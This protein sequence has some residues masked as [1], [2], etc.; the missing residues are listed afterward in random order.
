MTTRADYTRLKALLEEESSLTSINAL[1]EWDMQV[2]LPAK[3]GDSRSKQMEALAGVLHDK[4]TS[5]ELGALLEKM[6]NDKDAQSNDKHELDDWEQAVVREAQRDY[7]KHSS[8]PK[9]LAQR[10]AKLATEGYDI[11]VKAR[12]DNDFKAFAPVLTQWIDLRK[13]QCKYI[14][15]SKEVYDVCLDMHERGLSASRIDEIFEQV[16]KDLIPL[17]QKIKQKEGP[18][19]S[20]LEGKFDVKT[21]IE[22]N[23][24]L[25]KMLGFDMECG[26]LDASV[27][28]FTQEIHPTDVRMT[29]RFKDDDIMEGITGTIHETG[30]SLYEQGRNKEYANLPVSKALS[31]GIHESQSL[32]WERMVGLGLPFWK[33]FSPTVKNHFPQIPASTTPEQFFK[34]INQVKASLIRVEADE[35][36]YPLHIILRHEIESGLLKGTIKV[37]DLPAIWN[38][39]MEEYLGILPPN[40]SE[41]VLQDTHWACGLFGY[42][43]TYALGAIYASQ[44]YHQAIKEIPDLEESISKGNFANLK[45]WLNHKIH[46]KGSLIPS[47]D[48]LT[49]QVTGQPLNPKIF[50]GYLNDKYS[51]LYQLSPW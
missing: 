26:R 33:F 46:I 35:V 13:E 20:F 44:F 39:K 41:G 43:P 5:K 37:E 31:M 49:K 2:M 1:L 12:K 7:K 27:H 19:R 45:G 38:S 6:Q 48:L 21:Q 51:H 47:G 17:I 29:T 3:S 50:T 16:K 18:D 14:D 22:L 11:W 9:E 10:E 25:A 4:R 42:F 40:D 30:H 34:G 23:H 28:P 8:V 32:L 24:E 15:S 36:T